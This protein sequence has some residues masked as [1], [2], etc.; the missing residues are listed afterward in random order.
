MSDIPIPHHQAF[1]AGVD[2]A[3]R[4][5]RY[6]PP[7]VWA[8]FTVHLDGDHAGR[9]EYE[10]VG[11]EGSLSA[12][13]HGVF[14]VEKFSHHYVDGVGHKHSDLQSIEVG[15]LYVDLWLGAFLYGKLLADDINLV[16]WYVLCLDNE[17]WEYVDFIQWLVVCLVG[18]IQLNANIGQSERSQLEACGGGNFEARI[19]EKAWCVLTTGSL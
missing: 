18:D 17:P 14:E 12:H 15:G 3:L 13:E 9:D 19:G 11:G 2:F 1:I 6:L 8:R 7:T 10:I 5:A 4:K 16:E